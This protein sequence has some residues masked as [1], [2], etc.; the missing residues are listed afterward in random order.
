MNLPAEEFTLRLNLP[1]KVLLTS[2][3]DEY[4][5]EGAVCDRV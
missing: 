1:S 4:G 3:D 5:A 2:A